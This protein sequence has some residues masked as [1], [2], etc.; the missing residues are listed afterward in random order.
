[1]KQNHT[2]GPWVTAYTG[3]YVYIYS[4]HNEQISVVPR[5]GTTE[6]LSNAQLIASA[7]DMAIEIETLREALKLAIREMDIARM[8]GA[9]AARLHTA[10]VNAGAALAKAERGN[11]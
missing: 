10:I 11:V 6:Q 3:D 1:M 2:P 4:E 5:A 7:P 9:N 8:E